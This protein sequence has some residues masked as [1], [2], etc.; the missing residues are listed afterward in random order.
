MSKEIDDRLDDLADLFAVWADARDADRP[1]PLLREVLI[2]ACD[3]IATSV[4][5]KEVEA[6]VPQGKPPEEPYVAADPMS[7]SKVISAWMKGQACDS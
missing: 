6:V 7:G 2:R 5:V 1:T 3:D 4:I